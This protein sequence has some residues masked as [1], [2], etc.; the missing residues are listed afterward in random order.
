MPEPLPRLELFFEGPVLIFRI[1]LWKQK[2]GQKMI[3]ESEERSEGRIAQ[4]TWVKG[5]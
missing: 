2:V 5:R 1:S 3:R 4:E